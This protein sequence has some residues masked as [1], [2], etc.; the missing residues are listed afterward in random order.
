MDTSD[1]DIEFDEKG[2]SNHWQ[3]FKRQQKINEYYRDLQLKK[4]VKE[5]KFFGKNK[6]YDTIVGVSGGVD[7][8][9]VCY[10]AKELGLKPLAVHFDN[11]WNSEIAVSNI[12]NSIKARY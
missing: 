4:L 8:T 2:I 6:K 10:L 1:P 11:G 12:E 7:S 5:I 9:Y 3:L